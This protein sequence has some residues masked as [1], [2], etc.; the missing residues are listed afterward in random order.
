MGDRFADA[1]QC[2]VCLKYPGHTFLGLTM[3][4]LHCLRGIVGRRLELG[5][6][7]MDLGGGLRGALSQLANLI[8]HDSE[9]LAHVADARCFDGGIQCQQIGLVGDSFD[10]VND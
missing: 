10:H 3:T 7:V 2:L 8:G 1:H 5:D 4:A 6:Q 9:T